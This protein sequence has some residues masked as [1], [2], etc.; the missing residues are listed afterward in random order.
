MTN[1][2]YKI[3][4]RIKKGIPDCLRSKVW[5]L[6]LDP[7]ACSPKQGD[8]SQENKRPSIQSYILI[9]R[10]KSC[11]TIEADLHRTMP[12]VK[13][14]CDESVINFLREILHAYSNKDTETGYYLGMAFLAAILLVYLDEVQVF[15]FFVNLMNG[16]KLQFRR[17]FIHKF[18]GLNELNL[19]WEK[20]LA[21]K[22]ACVEK[23][24]PILYTPAWFLCSYLSL[25]FESTL[26]LRI[27]DRT[28]MFGARDLLSF[29]LTII[30]LN[31][32]L[33]ETEKAPK[34][35]LYLQHPD[36]HESFKDWRNVISKFD[37][38]WLSQSDYDRLFKITNIPKF[39]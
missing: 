9:G 3:K 31:K 16:P 23:I 1:K 39:F 37:E 7:E 22:F 34:I 5:Q 11:K 35:L 32:K 12:H 33:L 21:L 15:W 4:S 30:A 10:S 17:L 2:L 36:E 24:D 14:F 18:S 19:V 29:G 8:D 38:L 27:F 6:L 25:P 13:M 26:K 20:L 28:L